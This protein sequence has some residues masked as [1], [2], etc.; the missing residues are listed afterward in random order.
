M[1]EQVC[2]YYRADHEAPLGGEPQVCQMVEEK[3]YCRNWRGSKAKEVRR[4]IYYEYCTLITSKE[5]EN[6]VIML[7]WSH[8]K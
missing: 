3:K 2:K 7:C 8:S 6:L 1:S 4:K 5:E